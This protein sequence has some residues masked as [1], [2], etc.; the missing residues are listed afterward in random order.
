MYF[1]SNASRERAPEV[2]DHGPA[3]DRGAHLDGYAVI[4]TS[5][6]ED[7]DLVPVLKVVAGR[8]LPCPHWGYVTAGRLTAIAPGEAPPEWNQVVG[9]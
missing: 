9:L 4:F 2:A 5:F 1:I 3:E 7:W 6:R 8:Q